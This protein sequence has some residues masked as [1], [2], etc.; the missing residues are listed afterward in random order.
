MDP[1]IRE[2]IDAAK[3]ARTEMIILAPRLREP[4]VS[5]ALQQ[6]A[7]RI[8]LAV[9]ALDGRFDPALATIFDKPK[10]AQDVVDKIRDD[11]PDWS[12]DII[13]AGDKWV[14]QVGDE[15]GDFL[16]YL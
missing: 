1:R 5:A 8:K 13:P 11:D 12:Y 10:L 4:N 6:V 16:G 2:L 9:A 15:S 3:Q 14:I 7:G